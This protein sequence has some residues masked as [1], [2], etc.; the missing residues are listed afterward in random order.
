MTAASPL[1]PVQVDSSSVVMI[2]GDKSKTQL[3]CTVR[4]NLRTRHRCRDDQCAPPILH[5]LALHP[6]F[7]PPCARYPHT[8]PA[9]RARPC[10]IPP[11]PVYRVA[12]QAAQRAGPNRDIQ[13]GEQQSPTLHLLI[14]GDTVN[15]VSPTA[16]Q[17]SE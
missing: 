2:R 9:P 7:A 6:Y 8:D 11:F 1:A 14:S 10:C 15:A 13:P 5:P 17:G 16:S 3:L 4:E 12:A